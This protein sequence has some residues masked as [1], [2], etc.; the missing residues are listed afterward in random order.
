[1]GD[2]QREGAPYSNRSRQTTALILSRGIWKPHDLRRTGATLMNSL[3]VLPEVAERC[4]N[5]VEENKV[6]RI[7]HRYG[8]EA[9]MEQ[10]WK[11]L[12]EK[13]EML[14]NLEK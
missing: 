8:Y 7:Y 1:M 13:L 3:G 10:A 11:N 14:M 6:K 4:L 9:E 12:G 5:H 2:R